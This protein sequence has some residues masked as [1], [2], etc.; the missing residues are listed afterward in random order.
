ME[1]SPIKAQR[2][3]FNKFMSRKRNFEFSLDLV[4]RLAETNVGVAQG[5]NAPPLCIVKC[6]F[7][8]RKL[9]WTYALPW[10]KRR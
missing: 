5:I 10:N 1:K 3:E 9:P 8:V 2:I 4:F 6:P 7:T